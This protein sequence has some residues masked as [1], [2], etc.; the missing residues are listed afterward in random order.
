MARRKEPKS[1]SIHG[2]RPEKTF[3][4]DGQFLKREAKEA[5]KSYFMPLWGLYA[6]AAGKKVIIVNDREDSVRSS[7]V[8][9]KRRA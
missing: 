8:T 2:L 3:T 4:L 9:A 6:A 7:R 5:I 1:R